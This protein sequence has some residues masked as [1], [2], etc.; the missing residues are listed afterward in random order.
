VLAYPGCPGKEVA[1]RVAFWTDSRLGSFSQKWT[2]GIQTTASTS[3]CMDSDKAL[4]TEGT[5]HPF[6]CQY[7]LNQTLTENDN[8]VIIVR[9]LSNGYFKMDDLS[10][11]F[12]LRHTCLVLSTAQKY[13]P[14]AS[15]SEIITQNAVSLCSYLQLVNHCHEAV[16]IRKQNNCYIA[17]Q[18]L[19]LVQLSTDTIN[20]VYT[21]KC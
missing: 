1:K 15:E 18:Y 9:V 5:L 20:M 16:Y 17:Q 2:F 21:S 11:F 8:T 13:W 12:R 4:I 3:R 14:I 6:L 7:Q 10:A 19:C